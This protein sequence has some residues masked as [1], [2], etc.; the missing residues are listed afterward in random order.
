MKDVDAKKLASDESTRISRL[1]K[2][3]QEIRNEPRQ[4]LNNL[5]AVFNISRSQFYKDKDALAEIGFKFSYHR[6]KGFKI[7]EDKLAPITGF[8]LSDRLILM[9]ALEHLSSMGEAHLTARAMEIGRKLAGGLDEPFRSQ[10]LECFDHRVTSQAYGVNPKIINE[11]QDSIS[12]ERRIKLLYQRSGDWTTRWREVD[13]RRIYMRGR[14][15]YLYARTVDEIPLQWKVFRLNRIKE[16]QPTGMYIN[17]PIEEE[18]GFQ[19]RINNAFE[20]IIGDKAEEVTICF[21]Q[22]ACNYIKEKQ[23]HHSQ[24]IQEQKDGSLLLTVCVAD[25]QEVVRWAR[26]FDANATIVHKS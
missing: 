11:L 10:L 23:W 14:T 19:N 3:V 8:S 1:I 9:F 12:L 2:M 7:E 15:L 6:K 5:L 21:S 24:R 17:M 13:P 16:L 22:Q 26:Q 25:P 20:T 18:D 4:S